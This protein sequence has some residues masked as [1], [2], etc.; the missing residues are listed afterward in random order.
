MAIEEAL[1]YTLASFAGPKVPP[2]DL[3]PKTVPR[4]V[5]VSRAFQ[6]VRPGKRLK[7]EEIVNTLRQADVEVARGSTVAVVC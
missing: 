2:T 5:W 1:L 7:A 4:R 3:S 6:E